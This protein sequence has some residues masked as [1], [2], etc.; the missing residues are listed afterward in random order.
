MNDIVRNQ[1]GTD[2]QL[3]QEKGLL[4]LKTELQD[5]WYYHIWAFILLQCNSPW[6]I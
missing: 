6:H 3:G 5:M 2:L 4:I 1:A